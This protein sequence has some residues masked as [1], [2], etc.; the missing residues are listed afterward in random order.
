V[1]DQT[2]SIRFRPDEKQFD[3]DGAY[4][5]RYEIVKKRIDKAY[6][7]NTNE[8]LTQPGKIAIVY[9]QGRV[10]EEY[11]RYFQYLISKNV[12]KDTIEEVE[13]EELP[14][15]TGLRA[16]RIELT[17]TTPV[18]KVDLMEELEEALKA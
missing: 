12:I 7:K 14:G 16:L 5:I 11:R 1:H 10:E 8:R 3:V 13:L 6:L 2:I 18:N 15:A 17:G 4:D 9:S